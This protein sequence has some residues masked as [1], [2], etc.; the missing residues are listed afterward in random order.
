M[1]KR[2]TCLV[3]E[4]RSGQWSCRV[5]GADLQ[6]ATI[7]R[8]SKLLEAG[9]IDAR[10]ERL[11]DRCEEILGHP[12]LRSLEEYA[13]CD[14]EYFGEYEKDVKVLREN[15]AVYKR[16]LEQ[17]LEEVVALKIPA[18]VIHND[19]YS[20]NVS[21]K[22]SSGKLTIYDWAG[23]CVG[24]PFM[25]DSFLWGSREAESAYLKEWE[26]YGSEDELRACFRS[27]RRF[28]VLMEL[29]LR[30]N[31]TAGLEGAS[32]REG[33]AKVADQ[34]YSIAGDIKSVEED[35][36]GLEENCTT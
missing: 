15:A 14:E 18:T 22:S 29:L 8:R 36:S 30:L 10:P 12:E 27:A 13:A 19:L 34:V 16:K 17:R 9:M 35:V 3:I 23:G 20:D 5:C 26:Q 25:D 31:I 11:L 6:M 2:F 28:S 32:K 24:H 7:G 4:I 33:L 21:R 1:E